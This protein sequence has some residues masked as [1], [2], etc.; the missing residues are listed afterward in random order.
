MLYN[1]IAFPAAKMILA[2]VTFLF[3]PVQIRGKKNVPDRGGVLIVANHLSDADPAV[4]GHALRRKAH[5]M[6]K[7]ELFSI[8]ILGWIIRT[9]RAFPVN[10]GSPDRAAIRKTVELL[11]AGEAV[12]MFPEGQLSE[13][14]QPQPLM[15]GAAMIVLRSGV[16][17]V[18]VG[19]VGTNKIIPFKKVCPRP[20]FGGVKVRFGNPKYFDH[21]ASH[22]DV[23][24]WISSELKRLT[25]S[26]P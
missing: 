6:A 12:V 15:P 13:T 11:R 18:C 7:S 17:V 14:G 4:L 26:R 5:Y 19:L 21:E 22:G 25:E 24:K 16:P 1:L 20:A 10:R 2:A 9:L 3:G 8:P 23:L